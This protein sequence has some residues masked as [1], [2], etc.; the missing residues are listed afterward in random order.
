MAAL[1][2]RRVSVFR[3]FSLRCRCS[4]ALSSPLSLREQSS[5]HSKISAGAVGQAG[6]R[7]D[8]SCSPL[9]PCFSYR[10]LGGRHA[11]VI[12]ALPDE[13][14][15]PP[16]SANGNGY[17]EGEPEPALLLPPAT[18]PPSLGSSHGPAQA[19][20][21]RHGALQIIHVEKEDPS[22]RPRNL[23]TQQLVPMKPITFHQEFPNAPHEPGH[24]GRRSSR[25]SNAGVYDDY[26]G[27]DAMQVDSP[28]LS[29]SR[30]A[31]RSPV[32]LRERDR[33]D[34]EHDHFSP[35][36]ALPPPAMS[37]SHSHPQ[38]SQSSP[39]HRSPYESHATIP[40]GPE[41]VYRSATPP[42]PPVPATFA[43]IM[44]AYPAPPK[45]SPPLPPAHEGPGPEFVHANGSSRRNGHRSYSP[46]ANR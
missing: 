40:N 17:F 24:R 6:E 28:A 19:P 8:H 37:H 10:P 36:H 42:P 35:P 18:L 30:T 34:R 9:H 3:L 21:G 43:S 13:Q 33:S 1:R 2:R 26:R 38:T 16:A 23:P 5:L 41:P 20:L 25:T 12:P 29:Q 7:S 46:V 14:D 45:I 27:G 44:N 22:L 31:S 39:H 4:P 32:L 11:A 15:S